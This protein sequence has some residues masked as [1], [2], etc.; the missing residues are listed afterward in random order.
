MVLKT[1]N[2]PGI[3]CE[4]ACTARSRIARGRFAAS[5]QLAPALL[6][7]VERYRIEYELMPDLRWRARI[8]REV[9]VQAI[10]GQLDETIQACLLAYLGTMAQ[11]ASLNA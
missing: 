8:G 6:T 9:C 3:E 2:F 4:L 5:G 1:W 10:G 11:L 7:L